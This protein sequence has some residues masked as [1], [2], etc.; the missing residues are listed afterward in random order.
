MYDLFGTKE[1]GSLAEVTQERLTTGTGSS[2]EKTQEQL[3]Q[4]AS[5][6]QSNPMQLCHITSI[7]VLFNYLFFVLF[8]ILTIS[9]YLG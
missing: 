3:Y 9:S 2:D 7:Y 1:T 5:H 4:I 6:T 8:M